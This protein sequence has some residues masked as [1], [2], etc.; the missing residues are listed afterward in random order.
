MTVMMAGDK[1]YKYHDVHTKFHENP[2]TVSKNTV[3]TDS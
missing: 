3:A 2:P 1:K